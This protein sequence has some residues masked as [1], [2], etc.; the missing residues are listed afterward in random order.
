M[1][2]K[3]PKTTITGLVM[4]V[5]GLLAYFDIAIPEGWLMPIILVGSIALGFFAKDKKKEN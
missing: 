4:G 1:P 5:A 2:T 3:D